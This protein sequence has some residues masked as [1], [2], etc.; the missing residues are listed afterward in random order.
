M[1]AV[2]E[3]SVFTLNKALQSQTAMLSEGKTPEEVQASLGESFK[4]EGEKLAYFV[5]SLEVASGNASNLK[6]VL[7][8]KLN[9]G[10]SAPAKAMQVEDICYVPEFLITAKPVQA[11]PANAK[12]GRPG[13]NRGGKGGG[14]PKDSPWGLSPEEKAAKNKKPAATAKA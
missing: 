10:E 9:E 13:G 7:V 3:F 2:T 8:V 11:Q 6:R 5:K 4:F 1:K 14:A 12:G